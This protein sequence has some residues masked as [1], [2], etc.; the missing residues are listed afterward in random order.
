MPDP[1]RSEKGQPDSGDGRMDPWTSPAVPT[2]PTAPTSST[3]SPRRPSSQTAP[4]TS[5]L[6][7]STSG[8]NQ[9]TDPQRSE[10]PH[11]LPR[12]YHLLAPEEPR[13]DVC[14]HGRPDHHAT[15]RQLAEALGIDLPA[16]AA[17]P[18]Q[19]WAGL[20]GEVRRVRRAA[21]FGSSVDP[22]ENQ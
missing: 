15:L 11:V 4:S 21:Q 5:R 20:L 18:E 16:L 2:A 8:T 7:S 12:D 17:T 22:E 14:S 13:P 3:L 9:P 1:Q 6:S 19:V 10:Y